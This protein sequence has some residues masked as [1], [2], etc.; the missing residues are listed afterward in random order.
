MLI[1]TDGNEA[2]VP[3]LDGHDRLGVR[4]RSCASLWPACCALCRSRR[5][6]DDATILAEK[7]TRIPA[8]L[9]PSQDLARTLEELAE[10]HNHLAELPGADR[11]Q[12]CCMGVLGLH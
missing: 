9:A 1:C 5:H 8:N 4:S 10:L 3:T 11:V 12:L 2:N 7:R 6:D